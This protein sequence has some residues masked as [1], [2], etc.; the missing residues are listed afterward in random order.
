MTCRPGLVSVTFRQL[1][2]EEV[3]AAAAA[4]RLAAIEWGGDV[5]VPHG[6]LSA[7]SRVAELTTAAGLKVAAYGSYYRLAH[8]DDA[9]PVV[10]TAAALG[11][12]TVRVWAGRR[13]SAEADAAYWAAVVADAQR[14]A[15]LAADAGMSISFEYHRNTL[16]DTRASTARLLDALPGPA[17]RTLWQP[18]PERDREENLAD[19]RAVLPRLTNLHV[20]A[21][22]ATGERRPLADGTADWQAYLAEAA[23]AP[24]ERYALLEFVVGDDPA[25][26]AP[27][28]ATLAALIAAGRS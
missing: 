23:A 10:R 13:P 12:E 19:L 27:D 6:D 28:A 7:A 2:P 5:H 16:T 9:V 24:G 20:F 8:S 4:A 11:A 18:Q 14:L 22:T 17:I 25:R 1:T 3:I 21:W 15:S 26:L